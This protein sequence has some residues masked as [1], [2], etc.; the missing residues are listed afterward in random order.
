MR[1]PEENISNY[2]L[3]FFGYRADGGKCTSVEVVGYGFLWT[4][5]KFD[6]KSQNSN[7]E[8]S[9]YNE[10]NEIFLRSIYGI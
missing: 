4:L 3:F 1:Y 6:K 5:I 7:F 9:F 8:F 10:A 2:I